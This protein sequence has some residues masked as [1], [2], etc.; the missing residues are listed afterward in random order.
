[1]LV[2]KELSGAAVRRSTR[3]FSGGAKAKNPVNGSCQRVYSSPRIQAPN[4]LSNDCDT[5]VL[6]IEHLTK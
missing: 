1:M 5:Q 4:P 2:T 6:T 3:R